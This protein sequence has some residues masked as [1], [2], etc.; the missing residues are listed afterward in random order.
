MYRIQKLLCLLALSAWKANSRSSGHEIAWVLSNFKT[1]YRV[2]NSSPVDSTLSRQPI[3]VQIFAL[4][5]L[6]IYAYFLQD[7]TYP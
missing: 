7:I 5:Y 4:Y 2:L 6:S 1:H 3:P